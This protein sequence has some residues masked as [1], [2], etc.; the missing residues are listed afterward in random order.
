MFSHASLSHRVEAY[1][2]TLITQAQL[3]DKRLQNWLEESG[4]EV[5][6]ASLV[7]L[8]RMRA[9]FHIGCCIIFLAILVR[10][11]FCERLPCFDL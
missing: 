8:A 1:S 9:L 4:R 11:P 7:M 3:E 5:M 10:N 6:L 2:R